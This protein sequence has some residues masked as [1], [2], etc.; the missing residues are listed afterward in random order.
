MGRRVE[1]FM[2]YIISMVFCIGSYSVWRLNFESLN[3]LG[4]QCVYRDFVELI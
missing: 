3:L 2:D 4:M 1:R